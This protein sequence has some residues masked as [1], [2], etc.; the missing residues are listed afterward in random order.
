MNL[1]INRLSLVSGS[2]RMAQGWWLMALCQESAR[3]LEWEPRDLD[4]DHEPGPARLSWPWA[5]SHEP[6][7]IY[8]S[9]NQA[10]NQSINQ[11]ISKSISINS[12]I[13]S[14][15]SPLGFHSCPRRSDGFF[16]RR[17]T[18]FFNLKAAETKRTMQNRMRPIGNRLRSI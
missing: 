12:S 10:I 4:Q 11:S 7:T 18:S 15:H 9:I 2:W 6:Q 8:Q 5:W 13:Y 3:G 17:V 14:E 16:V 1:S